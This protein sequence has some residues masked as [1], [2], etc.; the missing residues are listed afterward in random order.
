MFRFLQLR[1]KHESK[2]PP[3]IT[4]EESLKQFKEM[5][6]K[7]LSSGAKRLL[8]RVCSK[9]TAASVLTDKVMSTL[10]FKRPGSAARQDARVLR[11]LIAHEIKEMKGKGWQ[12]DE[13]GMNRLVQ[14]YF[15]LREFN[16]GR[17]HPLYYQSVTTWGP[18]F[19]NEADNNR[20][21]KFDLQKEEQAAFSFILERAGRYIAPLW[22][23]TVTLSH[24]LSIGE[25]SVSAE[26]AYWLGLIDEVIGKNWQCPRRV[27][28]AREQ[29]EPTPP[30]D[31]PLESK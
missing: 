26:D 4:P 5:L 14:D 16:V 10:S 15:L 11:A 22:F 9:V 28:E 7:R 25:N 2:K 18:E 17:H 3:Q 29:A 19:L 24:N 21:R 12:L 1:P 8:E 27:M 30:V 13:L 6:L 31:A 23:F 20:F